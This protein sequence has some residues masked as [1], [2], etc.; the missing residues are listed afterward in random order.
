MFDIG[1]QRVDVLADQ[2]HAKGIEIR[3]WRDRDVQRE[4]R[5]GQPPF[6]PDNT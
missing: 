1:Q 5:Q 6:T 2:I 4:R 3:S